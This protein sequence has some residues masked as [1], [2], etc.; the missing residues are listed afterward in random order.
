MALVPGNHALDPD[1]FIG[2]V[3]SLLAAIATAGDRRLA[4]ETTSAPQD[5]RGPLSRRRDR[6]EPADPAGTGDRDVSRGKRD[7]APVPRSRRGRGPRA[8]SDRFAGAVVLVTG[9]AGGIGAAV[10]RSLALKEPT[11]PSPTATLR[12]PKGSPQRSRCRAGGLPRIGSTWSTRS[13]SG[14]PSSCQDAVW[15]DHP[16]RGGRRDHRHP[17]VPRTDR[18]RLGSNNGGQSEGTFLTF[19]AVARQMVDSSARRQSRGHLVDCRPGWAPERD[20]LRRQQGR[21]HQPGSLG[22]SRPGPDW[23]T[24]NAVC[25]GIVDTDMTAPS[26]P[27][28][29]DW[30]V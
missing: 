21:R 4:L 2:P 22:R 29:R 7:D 15:H 30:P 20:G 1:A 27:T 10:A 12:V 24:V 25:P 11:S 17:S 14:T 23:I 6:R 13:P 8:V 26:T 19:Q 16:R 18:P 28:A 5:H 3:R 9:G